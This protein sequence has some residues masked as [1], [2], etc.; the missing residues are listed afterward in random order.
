MLPAELKLQ[1]LR[2]IAATN[3][4]HKV[5]SAR[6]VSDVLASNICECFIQS[7]EMLYGA[8]LRMRP[9]NR[10]LVSQQLQTFMAR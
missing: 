10:G 9:I 3:H 1:L 8:D 2:T 7:D 6:G 4:F 5:D